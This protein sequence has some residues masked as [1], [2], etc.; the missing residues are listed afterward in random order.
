[1]SWKMP[2]CA[3]KYIQAQRSTSPVLPSHLLLRKRNN[4][5]HDFKNYVSIII[6]RYT[7]IYSKYGNELKPVLSTFPHFLSSFLQPAL[8]PVPSKSLLPF[9]NNHDRVFF[10]AMSMSPHDPQDEGADKQS[11][12]ELEDTNHVVDT[13]AG[14]F[15]V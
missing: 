9:H 7:I 5:I 12:D 10:A 6:K 8:I 3:D 14:V 1:M 2:V 4:V 15:R 13:D 11:L